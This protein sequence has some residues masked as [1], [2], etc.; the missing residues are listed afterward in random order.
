M[1]ECFRC[2]DGCHRVRRGVGGGGARLGH[3]VKTR[4]KRDSKIREID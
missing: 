2:G 1:S 4:Q 3:I